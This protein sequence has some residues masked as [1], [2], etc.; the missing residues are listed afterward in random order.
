MNERNQAEKRRQMRKLIDLVA[1]AHKFLDC[2]TSGRINSLTDVATVHQTN[3]SEVSRLIPLAFLSPK[4]VNGLLSG[5]QPTE[6]TAQRL[7]RV[8]ELPVSWREQEAVLEF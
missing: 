4:I 5:T 2:L 1:R 6:V 7:S 8:G 3:L